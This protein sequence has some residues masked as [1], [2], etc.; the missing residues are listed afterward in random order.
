[1]VTYSRPSWAW[2]WACL[3]I[4]TCTLASVG[5]PVISSWYTEASRRTS[6][7][8]CRRRSVWNGLVMYAEAPAR[9]A[10]TMLASSVL[11]VRNTTGMSLV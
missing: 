7:T 6:L 1:M 5:R 3:W 4:W 11:A 8:V 9:L 10:S 2:S